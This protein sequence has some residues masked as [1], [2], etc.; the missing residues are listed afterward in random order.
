MTNYDAPAGTPFWR[1][2]NNNL[3][4]AGTSMGQW[5]NNDIDAQRYIFELQT[6]G[7]HEPWQ[8]PSPAIRV[9][10]LAFA[11]AVLRQVQQQQRCK[12]SYALKFG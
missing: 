3:A 11:L 12:V 6:N 5:G 8:T 9:L 10:E 1:E 2:L 4:P 7:S